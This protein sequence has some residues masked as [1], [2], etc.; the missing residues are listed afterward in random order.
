MSAAATTTAPLPNGNPAP[1]SQNNAS[2]ASPST[3][4]T[5]QSQSQSQLATQP[6]SAS[7]APPPTITTGPATTSNPNT[8]S[9]AASAAAAAAS[10]AAS[11]P[12]PRDARTIELLLTAQGVT[13]FE[14]RVPLLLLDF[15]YRHTSAVLSDALHL[16]ADP[17]T[18]HAG[19][20]PSASS[21]AAPVNVG[22]ATITSNAVQL[23]I[24]SRLNFQFRGGSGG[25]SG[26]GVSKEW[27]MEMAR[28]KNKVALPK[29][30]VNEWGVRLPS[31]R[32]VL[33]GVSWGLKG[34]GWIAGGDE[35]SGDEEEGSDEDM[36]DA[37]GIN[38]KGENGDA[39]EGIERED[40]GGDGVEGGT[41]D[42]LF[43]DDDGDNDE[44]ED[45]DMFA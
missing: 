32:F 11:H 1:G 26:G 17:Y 43:G 18:S 2:A 21:G 30:S 31:E 15:A 24:A 39:M 13:A 3:A 5:S 33:N 6:S 27:M 7:Q 20:R 36:E 22:D 14:Q 41:V 44:M 37:M 4:A 16:S 28:E 19:A 9:T 10:S 8:L 23:A 25:G 35:T 42:D 12:R 45:V 38:K 40:I 34:D 29:V